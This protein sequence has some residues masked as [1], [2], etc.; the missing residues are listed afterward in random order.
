MYYESELNM[1]A[2]LYVMESMPYG[3]EGCHYLVSGAILRQDN[4]LYPTLTDIDPQY[5][6]SS[7]FLY[8]AVCR[9][10]HFNQIN[11]G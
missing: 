4:L 5:L 11:K 8:C 2:C 1:C 3:E 10:G 6:M 9:G 7:I